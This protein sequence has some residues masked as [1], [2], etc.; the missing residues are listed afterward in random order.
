[1]SKDILD[2]DFDWENFSDDLVFG[3]EGDERQPVVMLRT[4]N[5]EEQAQ[6]TAAA[7]RAEGIDAHVVAATT[8]QLTPFAY[9]NVRLFVSQSQKE[10]AENVL[11]DMNTARQEVYD[12]P[13]LSATRILIILVAGIFAMGLV[14][15]LIQVL[16][17]LIVG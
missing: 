10:M 3:K 13:N 14:I 17:G 9:G 2:D 5:T 11:A 12:E 7:L 15:R 1:M 6:L 8:G 16:F 4:F